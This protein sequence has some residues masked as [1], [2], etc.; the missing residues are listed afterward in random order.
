MNPDGTGRTQLTFDGV[1]NSNKQSVNL[2][3][4]NWSPDGSIMFV[5]NRVTGTVQ[6]WI[7][8]A[9]GSNPRVL[10]PSNY[11]GGRLPWRK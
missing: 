9:D 10:L 3:N 1:V 5:S 4:P 7:M 6:T 8:N 11:G 2:D